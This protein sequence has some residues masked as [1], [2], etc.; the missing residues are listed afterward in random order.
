MING[1]KPKLPSCPLPI[2][3]INTYV[4]SI[5]EHLNNTKNIDNLY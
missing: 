4:D 3:Y 5:I 1:W 2:T